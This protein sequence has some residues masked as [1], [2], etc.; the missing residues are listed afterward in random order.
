MENGREHGG[1]LG[2]QLQGIFVKDVLTSRNALSK[3][4]YCVGI[5]VKAINSVSCKHYR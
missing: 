4:F 5:K 3:S 2:V 1:T